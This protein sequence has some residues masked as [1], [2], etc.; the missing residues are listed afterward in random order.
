LSR[1]SLK[2]EL[3]RAGLEVD[4]TI[5][6]GVHQITDEMQY[7]PKE[8]EEIEGAEDDGIISINSRLVTEQTEAVQGENDL[9]QQGPG[10]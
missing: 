2:T 4:A 9:C 5:D 3:S 7:E 1:D 10:K 6:E 8:G